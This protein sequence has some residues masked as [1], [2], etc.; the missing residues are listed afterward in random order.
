ME[1]LEGGGIWENKT[2][3]NLMVSRQN[4]RVLWQLL[5][6]ICVYSGPDL[7]CLLMPY[8]FVLTHAYSSVKE[9]H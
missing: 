6:F 7:C 9:F 4:V 1:S 3:F 5:S 2:A 8:I